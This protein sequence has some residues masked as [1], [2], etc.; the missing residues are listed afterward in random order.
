MAEVAFVLRDRIVRRLAPWLGA[1]PGPAE[2]EPEEPL[3]EVAVPMVVGQAALDQ[4]RRRLTPRA[5][6]PAV[7][8]DG[9]APVLEARHVVVRFGGN[10]AVDGVSLEVRPGEVVGLVGPNGA[11]KTTLFDVLSGHLWP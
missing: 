6:S 8:G 4:V 10:A 5:P 7:D 11:G 2:P 3:E 9:A 1:R